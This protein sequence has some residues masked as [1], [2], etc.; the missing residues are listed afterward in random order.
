M[1]VKEVIKIRRSIRKFKNIEI[2]DDIIGEIIEAGRLAPSGCNAQPSRYLIIKDKESKEKLK[3]NNI[4]AQDFVYQAPVI[5]ICCTDLS[6]YKKSTDFDDTNKVRAIRDLSIASSYLD[7]RAVELGLGT[8]YIGDIDKVR[9]KEVLEISKDYIVL[10]ALIF[11]YPDES[12]QAR[13][14]HDINE[15]L[16]KYVL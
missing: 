9:V 13:P 14:R 4:F 8:C 1:N 12:P 3:E 7:L 5:I 2:T 11:G 16:I 6:V 10:F 15:I